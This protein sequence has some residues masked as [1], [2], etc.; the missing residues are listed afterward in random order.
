MV[1]LATSFS[2]VDCIL[3]CGNCIITNPRR[4]IIYKISVVRASKLKVPTFGFSPSATSF[5]LTFQRIIR[6][7]KVAST[8]NRGA[9]AFLRPRVRIRPVVLKE[10]LGQG[11]ALCRQEIL[12]CESRHDIQRNPRSLNPLPR[13]NLSMYGLTLSEQLEQWLCIVPA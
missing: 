2:V 5:L 12:W 1:L 6:R 8:Q 10:G 11:L 13:S 9:A 7:R 4:H 3:Q